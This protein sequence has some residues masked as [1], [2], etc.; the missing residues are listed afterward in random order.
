MV[1]KSKR[2]KA[3]S[4]VKGRPGSSTV[5]KNSKTSSMLDLIDAA[6]V[7][8]YLMA[9]GG[10]VG[11]GMVGP[12]FDIVRPLSNDSGTDKE[13]KILES[14]FR[15]TR[16]DSNNFKDVFG[17]LAKIY[18]TAFMFRILGVAA[19]ELLRDEAGNAV[20][21]DLVP[22]VVK[23]NIEAD[24][25]FRSPAYYQYLR[26]GSV[27]SKTEFSNPSDIVFFGVPD[28]GSGIYLSESYSLSEY[29][30]PSEIYAAKAY[31][32]L[33]E[34]KT[35]PYQGFW[36]TP[37]NIDDDTFDQFAELINVRYRGSENYGKSPII[38]R[39]KGGF[40]Y[41]APSK[42]D[43]PY[44]EGREVSRKEIAGVTGVPGAK[45]GHLE[46]QG[47]TGLK[48]V[49][50][51]FYESVLRPVASVMEEAIYHQICVREF[52]I[53]G[54]RFMFNR[55]D[56]TTAIEDAS[57]EMRRI[58]WGTSSPNEVR[59]RRGEAP[60][61]G[62]DYFLVPLN[63]QLI[64]ERGRPVDPV[65]DNAGDMKPGEENPVPGS[66]DP[67]RVEEV[68]GELRAWRKFATRVASGKRF[69]RDFNCDHIPL[70]LSNYIDGLI[71]SAGD[72]IDVIRSIFDDAIDVVLGE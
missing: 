26:H 68:I 2:T 4:L 43:A 52:G 54:W 21:F 71:D 8:P 19:W 55:P 9:S 16:A 24:G 48:E 12:G 13:K 5:G 46:G 49:R 44:V 40:E 56:F 70:G 3:A 72:D 45:Y 17:P 38:M 39:G 32:S 65:D 58:Q 69:E 67:V 25:R 31:L 10:T 62:G 22:G 53:T 20:G 57:I 66:E 33:H 47:S 64:D 15:G 11:R 41:I 35:S 6:E 61:E 37:E 30:L 60:R 18:T 14:F 36:Y 29:T 1:R 34:N 51:E 28:V 63:M 27:E 42:D 50:R 23:P 7:V 59:A